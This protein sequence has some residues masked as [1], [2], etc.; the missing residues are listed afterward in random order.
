LSNEIFLEIFDYLD[1]RDI[2]KTFCNLNIRFQQLIN[3]SSLLLKI[4]LDEKSSLKV[5]ISD[6]EVIS[7]DKEHILSL[8]LCNSIFID[9]IFMKSAIR[10]S[11]H[12]LE[13]LSLIDIP[14]NKLLEILVYLKTLPR[15]FSLH[16]DYKK[17]YSNHYNEIYRMIL[18]LPSLKYNKLSVVVETNL[19]I[20]IPLTTNDRFSNIEY[21]VMSHTC[22]LNEVVSVLQHIPRLKHL[23]CRTLVELNHF[24]GNNLSLTIPNL[25][26]IRIDTCRVNLDEFEKFIKK[27]CS[28]LQSLRINSFRNMNFIHP[29][30]WARLISKHMPHLFVFTLNFQMYINDNFGHIDVNIVGNP[31]TLRFW[32]ER[33]W[34]LQLEA[35]P[36]EI[37]YQISLN[38]YHE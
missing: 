12:R 15:L 28:Q 36:E 25:K 38:K 3:S 34:M 26:H 13:S 9:E 2:Y 6:K 19:Y 37:V 20:S 29:E 4:S 35:K 7:L 21:L 23:I 11:F 5:R 14:I 17:G 16:I 27:I 8:R 18:H 33:E 22:N 32:T 24:I 10:S 31:H 30:R 1:G